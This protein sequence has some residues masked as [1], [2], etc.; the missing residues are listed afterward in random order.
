MLLTDGMESWC[1]L[2]QKLQWLIPSI[3]IRMLSPVPF[4]ELKQSV[5]RIQGVP[6]QFFRGGWR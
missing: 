6:G 2:I 5:L 3:S 1:A 4:N